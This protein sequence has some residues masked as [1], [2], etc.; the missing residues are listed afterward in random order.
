MQWMR[1]W[2]VKKMITWILNKGLARFEHSSLSCFNANKCFNLIKCQK[3][4]WF[5]VLNTFWWNHVQDEVQSKIPYWIAIT[6]NKNLFACVFPKPLDLVSEAGNLSLFDPDTVG[7]C[8]NNQF[9]CRQCRWYICH[10]CW[11][12]WKWEVNPWWHIYFHKSNTKLWPSC[13]PVCEK[14]VMWWG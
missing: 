6:I 2:T 11:L 8:E 9:Q 14:W 4:C 5:S 3:G 13:C 7:P 12:M 1:M 10:W